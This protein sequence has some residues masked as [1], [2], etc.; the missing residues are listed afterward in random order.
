MGQLLEVWPHL[1]QMPSSAVVEA[2]S[3][4]LNIMKIKHELPLTPMSFEGLASSTPSSN[5]ISGMA[6]FG[7]LRAS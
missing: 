3:G 6:V 1:P 5:P 2:G 4:V 7:T